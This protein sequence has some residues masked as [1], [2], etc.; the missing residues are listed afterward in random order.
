MLQSFNFLCGAALQRLLLKT[1][2]WRQGSAL[3]ARNSK[4]RGGGG[5][6]AAEAPGW[7][8]GGRSPEGATQVVGSDKNL[9]RP[10]RAG[11]HALP[12][13]RLAPRALLYCAFSAKTL[14]F[15]TGSP[16]PRVAWRKGR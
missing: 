5:R 12:F 4:A 1:D 3:K 2:K 6:R 14:S 13:P 15:E 7:D 16:E 10:F 8:K 9:C 11:S